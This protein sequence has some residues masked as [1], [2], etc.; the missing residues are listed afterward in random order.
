MSRDLST[1]TRVAL[2]YLYSKDMETMLRGEPRLQGL[3]AGEPTLLYHGTT[4]N[5]RAFDLTKS[6]DDLVNSYYGSGIFLSPS[7]RVAEKY[8][9]AN[10]NIGFDAEIVDDLKR[11]NPLAGGFLQRLVAIGNDA[12]EEYFDM[13]REQGH[14]YP[15]NAMEEYLGMD[16]NSLGDIAGYVIGSQ[17]KPLG[18]DDGPSLFSQSTGAPGWLYDLLDKVGLDS[19]KY[20]PKVYT[21]AV[22]VHNPLVTANQ[23]QARRAK[24]KGY[25]SVVFFGSRLVDGV[26]EV[27]VFSPRNTHIVKVEVV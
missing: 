27:A 8:A 17:I 9:E 6:R 2:R 3:V 21:V 14:E 4:R 20:R 11:V 26:P 15:G 1:A 25:D 12:W 5:F 23:A 22:V 13:L 7:K 18:G 16:P 10:R 19:S 24:S